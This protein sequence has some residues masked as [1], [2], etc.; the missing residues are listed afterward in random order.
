MAGVLNRP[1]SPP[2]RIARPTGPQ[3]G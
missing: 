1:D 2:K 3:S